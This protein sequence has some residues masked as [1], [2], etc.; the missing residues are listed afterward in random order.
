MDLTLQ[1]RAGFAISA[2]QEL[3][4]LEDSPAINSLRRVSRSFTQNPESNLRDL[5]NLSR[6]LTDKLNSVFTSKDRGVVISEVDEN[7]GNPL[8]TVKQRAATMKSVAYGDDRRPLLDSGA[9]G[10]LSGGLNI[11]ASITLRKASEALAL[12]AAKSMDNKATL[13]MIPTAFNPPSRRQTSSKSLIAFRSGRVNTN[14]SPTV[15]GIS[16]SH[17]G[18][19]PSPQ[20]DPSAEATSPESQV[21]SSKAEADLIKRFSFPARDQRRTSIAETALTFAD[22]FPAPGTFVKPN[23]SVDS[24]SPEK[25]PFHFSIVR[26]LTTSSAHEIIWREDETSSSGGSSS[27]VSPTDKYRVSPTFSNPFESSSVEGDALDTTSF[28]TSASPEEHDLSPRVFNS[29]SNKSGMDSFEA[30]RRFFAWTWDNANNQ[31]TENEQTTPKHNRSRSTTLQANDTTVDLRKTSLPAVQSSPYLGNSCS[32]SE[33]HEEP[34]IKLDDTGSS[35]APEQRGS[36]DGDVSTELDRGLAMFMRRSQKM[37]ASSF[38]SPAVGRTGK[39]GSTGSLVG[40][41]SHARVK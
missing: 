28:L 19:L 30:H 15:P 4:D 24:V 1:A 32:V 3:E 12:S 26:V 27:L 2:L 35:R 36:L 14:S 7:A 5:R 23:S 13:E 22:F 29:E 39:A 9:M 8:A 6:T 21:R 10:N 41:S 38:Q 25:T 33:W 31:Q 37:A 17:Q 34:I 40:V 18:K 16:F 11:P 20:S